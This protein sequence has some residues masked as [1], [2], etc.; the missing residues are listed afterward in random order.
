MIRVGVLASGRGSNL[1]AL[2][3]AAIP[4]VA[5]VAVGADRHRAKALERARAHGIDT[6]AV[7]KRDHADRAAFDSALAHELVRREVDWVC[8]AGFMKI[9]GASM[10]AAFPGRM[11]NIHPTLLPAFPGLRPH[12]QAL[13]AGV[14]I[15][16]CTVH[17]VDGGTDS[18]PIVAQ[19][20]VPVRP[21]DDEATLAARVLRMEH[22]VYPMALRWVAEGRLHVTDGRVAVDLLPGETPFLFDTEDADALDHSVP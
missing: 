10:L 17:I 8:H 3:D 21:G 14:K 19:G 22:R 18:G 16:G 11:L 5:I 15:S 2:I 13:A 4:G 7:L 1:Q 12:E 20:A 9:V 6:F